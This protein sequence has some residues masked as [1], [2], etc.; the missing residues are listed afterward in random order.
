MKAYSKEFYECMDMFEKNIPYG[1]R[2]ERTD[3]SIKGQWYD[4]GKTN[5]LFRQFLNG[6]EFAKI[7]I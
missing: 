4:D 5:E 1:C 6:Y 7:N 3:K 2:K